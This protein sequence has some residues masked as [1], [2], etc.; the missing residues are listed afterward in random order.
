LEEP[1]VVAGFDT[2]R[3]GCVAA[4]RSE[5]AGTFVCRFSMSQPGCLVL[6]LKAP[7]HRSADD[8]GLV[9]ALLRAEDLAERRVE[10]WIRDFPGASHVLDVYKGSRVDKRKVFAPKP[11]HVSARDALHELRGLLGGGGGGGP[12]PAASG[13][14][15]PSALTAASGSG[16]AGGGG[17]KGG[18]GGGGLPCASGSG[19]SAGTAVGASGGGGGAAALARVLSGPSVSMH[20][21]V[22]P[23]GPAGVAVGCAARFP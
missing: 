1:T 12:A 18:G 6:T 23:V 9:H 3:M 13:C 7:G 21:P 22:G 17:G 10:A 8:D 14:A 5:P 20:A 2:D 11:S 16:C 15:A 19:G 4:L